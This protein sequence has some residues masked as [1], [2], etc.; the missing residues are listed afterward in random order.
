MCYNQAH[1]RGRCTRRSSIAWLRFPSQ[2]LQANCEQYL[3]VEMLGFVWATMLRLEKVYQNPSHHMKVHESMEKTTRLTIRPVEMKDISFLWNMLYEAAAVA[4]SMRTL[5]KEKALSLPV[6]RKYVEE[7]GR[8]GDAGVIAL[9]EAEQPLGAAW[10]RLHP[11]S[12]PGYGFISPSIPEL[13]IGVR[14]NARSQ[15]I[16]SALLHALIEL[17]QIQGYA[18][19]SLS[20][21]RTNPALYLYERFGFH[22]AKVSE[23]EDTSVTMIKLLNE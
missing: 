14:V 22:D 17:A 4:E 8:P 20:V 15:G 18:A 10:Y 19:L 23:P 12:A 2:I 7:W 9:D 13:T 5:G 11:A 16:G 21:D 1:V 3:Q 6:N